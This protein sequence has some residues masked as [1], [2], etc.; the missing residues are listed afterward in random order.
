MT[1]EVFFCDHCPDR[2]WHFHPEYGNRVVLS[3]ID[4]TL[5]NTSQR[6]NLLPTLT[7]VGADWTSYQA[8]CEDDDLMA[9]TAKALELMRDTAQV[10]LV[11]SGRNGLVGRRTLLWLI[12]QGV[13]WD[14]LFLRPE[15]S[16]V[17]AYKP[18]VVDLVRAAG[19]EVVLALE[20]NESES[21]R[22]EELGVPV[23]SVNPRY[24]E[25]ETAQAKVH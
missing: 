4:S 15:G 23:L 24:R 1:T 2:Q 8:A 9:G 20:D 11:S 16:P 13:Q 18:H 7:G 3:D 5:A 25:L 21:R 14:A 17:A 19:L 6:H 12:R 10:V 22:L